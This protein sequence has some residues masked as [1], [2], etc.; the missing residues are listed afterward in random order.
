MHLWDCQI[1]AC[2]IFGT[3]SPLTWAVGNLHLALSVLVPFS[4]PPKE[5][6]LETSCLWESNNNSSMLSVMQDGLSTARGCSVASGCSSPG[7]TQWKSDTCAWLR[8]AEFICFLCITQTA[9]KSG[10]PHSP[11]LQSSCSSVP[12]ARCSPFVPLRHTVPSP[13][14]SWYLFVTPGECH[15]SRGSPWWF[16]HAFADV[17][18]KLPIIPSCGE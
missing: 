12:H 16:I 3:G 18:P 9:Q 8:G 14:P 15:F 13:S 1:P 11:L 4:A 7:V 17:R 10:F 6:L 2:C 5:L